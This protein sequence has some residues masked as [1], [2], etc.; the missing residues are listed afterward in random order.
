MQKRV[1]EPV[2]TLNNDSATNSTS[3]G[4]SDAKLQKRSEMRV[5]NMQDEMDTIN[6]VDTMQENG[7]CIKRDRIGIFRRSMSRV[8]LLCCP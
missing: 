8:W 5:H 6:I 7:D 1:I 2:E 3:E 4:L